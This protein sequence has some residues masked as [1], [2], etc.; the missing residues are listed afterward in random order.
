M[1]PRHDAP[2]VPP[3][4]LQM[5]KGSLMLRPLNSRSH[6]TS[7]SCS[8]PTDTGLH[9]WP[10]S[11]LRETRLHS[12]LSLLPYTFPWTG[13]ATQLCDFC[14][15]QWLVGVERWGAR[16]ENFLRPQGHGASGKL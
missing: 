8:P 9:T 3:V 7:A 12:P 6:S 13:P 11:G 2:P 1:S 4:L 10:V 16:E 5:A 15:P 14:F